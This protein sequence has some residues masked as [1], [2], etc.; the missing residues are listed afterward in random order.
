MNIHSLKLI[1]LALFAVTF[2]AAQPADD[3]VLKQVIIFGRHGVRSSSVPTEQL[4]TFSVLATPD[5]GNASGYVTTHGAADET[6]MGGY[7]RLWLTQEG[8]LTGNDSADAAFVYIR[9]NA[10]EVTTQPTAQAFASGLL[11]AA[12]VNIYVYPQANDPVIDPVPA[13]VALLDPQKAIAAVSGR[14][15]GDP[16]LLSSAYAPEFALTRSLLFNYPASQTPPLATPTG[17][18]DVTTLPIAITAGTGGS[19]ID[20]G[21]LEYVGA[22][23]DPFLMENADGLPVWGQLTPANIS[24][25]YRI[26]TLILDLEYRTPYLDQ[27]QSSN[28]ASHIVRSLVQA[29]TGN[30]MTGAL[31]NPSTKVVMLVASD[32]NVTGLAGLFHL[33]WILPGYPPDFCA[34]SGTLAFELR[35]SQSTGEYTVRASYRAQTLDQL[36]NQTPLTL[37]AP[38]AIAPLFIPGCSVDNA[39]FDCPLGKFVRV[40]NQVIDPHST[41]LVN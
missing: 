6:I 32:V 11:P 12:S 17:K 26:Y 8:L 22:S 40:A 20:V 36:R 25:T 4:N 37:D 31:G 18:T 24:Q 23:I 27:V 35:Q 15:G 1:T 34:P 7:Y 29:A 21:G 10:A 30:A 3:T 13:G 5:F 39:T 16:Q 2:L 19:P 33:D 14:L 9:A 28:V 41:D 38:P